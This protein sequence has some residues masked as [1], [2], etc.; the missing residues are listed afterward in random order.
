MVR[1]MALE[2]KLKNFEW[3]DFSDDKDE[4]VIRDNQRVRRLNQGD[5]KA[6]EE[7]YRCY[8]S[9]LGSFLMRY[10]N[11]KKMAEDIIHNVFFSLWEN[12]TSL[13]AC[14]TLKAYLYKSVRN[15]AFNQLSKEKKTDI[16]EITEYPGRIDEEATPETVLEM[17][18]LKQAYK[19]ALKTLP[20]KRRHIF[21]MHREDKLTYREIAEVLDISIKTVET[22]ISRSLKYLLKQ[23]SHFRK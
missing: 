4:R 2:H 14:G 11:S 20:E 1:V 10:V 17:K 8:Y 23:L 3:I 5:K 16:V 15:Q 13:K 22:Q 19:Y 9:Q 7:I 18:E 21:L 6:F 12:R